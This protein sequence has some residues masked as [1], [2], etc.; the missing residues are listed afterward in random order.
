LLIAVLDRH[1]TVLVEAGIQQAAARGDYMASMVD[2]PLI[3]PT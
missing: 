1:A 2:C 3:Y